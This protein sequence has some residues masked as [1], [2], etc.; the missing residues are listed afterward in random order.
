M[1]STRNAVGGLLF[2]AAIGC[3]LRA[4][5]IFGQMRDAVNSS[6][7]DN[8]RIPEIGPSTLQGKVIRLHRQMF[9]TSKLRRR[10]YQ[11][12]WAEVIAFTAA[13]VCW[14]RFKW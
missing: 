11:W 7:P 2:I 13:V 6:L 8:D 3:Q 5:W 10:L 12:W 4:I 1:I 14:A 9:P